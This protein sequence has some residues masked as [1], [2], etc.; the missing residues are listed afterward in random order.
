[1]LTVDFDYFD[2]QPGH[3]CVDLGCGEGRHALT[4]YLG[5][6]VTVLGFDLS[7]ADLKTAQS[8]ITDMAPH[9]PQGARTPSIHPPEN[10]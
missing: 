1:M 8:R 4:A 7:H 10:G 6:D 3:I 2:I 9:N 5:S